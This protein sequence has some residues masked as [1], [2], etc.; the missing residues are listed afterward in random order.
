[1]D[2]RL[3]EMRDELIK[4]YLKFVLRDDAPQTIREILTDDFMVANGQEEFAGEDAEFIAKRIVEA[5]G[6]KAE[7]I[8][9]RAH[10]LGNKERSHQFIP[11]IF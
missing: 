1:M 7:E 3:E 8:A 9:H 2:E 4:L 6:D 10:R 11:F 5:V